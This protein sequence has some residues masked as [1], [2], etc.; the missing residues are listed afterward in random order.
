[1][2]EEKKTVNEKKMGD[3]RK[4]YEVNGAGRR[5]IRW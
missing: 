3:I 5:G 4:F 2:A 1:M